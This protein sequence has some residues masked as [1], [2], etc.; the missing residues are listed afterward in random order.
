MATAARDPDCIFCKIID[1]Q[2][3]STVVSEDPDYVAIRDINPQAPVH[4]LILPREH[5][6]D[7]TSVQD[8]N[9]LGTLFAAAS[10]I[11]AKEGL[12]N[13]FRL[14]VNTGSESG[15]SVFHLHIHLLGGRPMRWPPG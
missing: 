11:A 1:K 15:Q 6:P 10:S 9:A 13:G 4:I 14:V 3:P 12:S 2:I 5:L 8:A 7:I